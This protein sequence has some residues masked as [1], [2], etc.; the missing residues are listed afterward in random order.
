MGRHLG[1]DLE[2]RRLAVPAGDPDRP[3]DLAERRKRLQVGQR[4][5]AGEPAQPRRRPGAD[6]VAGHPADAA[7]PPDERAARATERGGGRGLA[8][9]LDGG[10]QMTSSRVSGALALRIA[11]LV[12]VVVFLQ[13]GVV[14][15]VPVFGVNIDL[16]PLVV[17]FVGL[18]C[19]SALGAITGFAAGLLVDL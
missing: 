12:V 18:L 15:E 17:A 10:W 6:R 14:S 1:D 13:I 9:R 7:E 16:S 2:P 5:P 8:T 19:G 3:G 4:S 11:I